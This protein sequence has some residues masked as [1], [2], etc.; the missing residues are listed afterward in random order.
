MHDLLKQISETV[1]TR[2]EKH[3]LK[4]KTITLKIKF[5]DFKQITRSSSSA[6]ALNTIDEVLTLVQKLLNDI[7]FGEKKVRLIGVG[8]S[9]FGEVK[10]R[11]RFDGYQQS[12]FPDLP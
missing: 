11:D 1:A 10:V 4:G 6:V 2:L 5:E 8:F 7:D 12:L 9:N 3:Q